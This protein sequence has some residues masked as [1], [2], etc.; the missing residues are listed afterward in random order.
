VGSDCAVFD[1]DRA[2]EKTNSTA[3]YTS[4]G[5]FSMKTGNLDN[6]GLTV[7]GGQEEWAEFSFRTFDR[8]STSF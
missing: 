1:S 7:S 3:Y 2:P 8:F 4:A 6:S 5:I